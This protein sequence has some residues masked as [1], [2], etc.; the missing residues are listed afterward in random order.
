MHPACS[1]LNPA[2]TSSHSPLPQGIPS[3]S[4]LCI[5]FT[6]KAAA[7][8]RERLQHA[9]VDPR[10][11]TAATFHSFCFGLLRFFH[12]VGCV[13]ANA[14]PACLRAIASQITGLLSLRSI[15]ASVLLHVLMMTRGTCAAPQ[16]VGFAQCPT[17]WTDADLKRAV[18]LAL[19]CGRALGAF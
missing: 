15:K 17:V 11:L 7:E 10:G 9:G 14:L 19:R 16:A 6:N 8:V 3:K 13:P 18:G 2:A 5:T 1:L 12:K 4:I